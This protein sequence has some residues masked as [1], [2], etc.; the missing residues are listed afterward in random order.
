MTRPSV[1]HA[2][3]RPPGGVVLDLFAGSCSTGR[4]QAHRAPRRAVREGVRLKC[5]LA[6]RRL[7]QDM[8]NF[9]EPS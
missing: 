7:A 5:E 6:A 9:E 8:L 4:S 3:G 1:W 2:I